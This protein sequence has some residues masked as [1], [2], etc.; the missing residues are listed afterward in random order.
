LS[1]KISTQLR[2]LVGETKPDQIKIFVNEFKNEVAKLENFSS[3]VYIGELCLDSLDETNDNYFEIFCR[4]C[5]TD[6]DKEEIVFLFK[7]ITRSK[8]SEKYNAEIRYKTIFFSKI[9]HE[10]KNPLICMNELVEQVSSSAELSDTSRFEKILKDLKQ[11]K[12]M[13]NFLII[14][15]RDF[16]FFSQN[17]VKKEII[18]EKNQTDI[19]ELCDFIQ[20]ISNSLISKFNR[21]REVKFKVEISHRVPK[22]ILTDQWRLKQILINLIS[23]AIKFTLYGEVKL[24]ITSHKTDQKKFVRFQVEDTGVG[25]KEEI[26][27]KLFQPY[28]KIANF[29]NELGS[30]LGLFIV[31]DLVNK[32]G[33]VIEF[34]SNSD[35]TAFWFSLGVDNDLDDISNFSKNDSSGIFDKKTVVDAFNINFPKKIISSRNDSSHSLKSNLDFP[36]QTLSDIQFRKVSDKK[37]LISNPVSKRDEVILIAE[38]LFNE[39]TIDHLRKSK[40]E[41]FLN[42][43]VTDDEEMILKSTVRILQEVCKKLNILINI[44]QTEDGVETI[45]SVYKCL[46]KGI[47]IDIIISDET[48]NYLIGSRAAM[49]I[50]EITSKKNI[51]SIPFYIVSAYENVSQESIYI[52]QFLTKP[53]SKEKIET[54]LSN[55]ILKNN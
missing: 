32:L 12:S 49:I 51:K 36:D 19:I 13:S 14:L 11:I 27:K 53:F 40:E 43:I 6:F 8:L 45:F 52:K 17:I 41:K 22:H 24:K 3:L 55:Y 38:N 25:I 30:G 47:T 2:N 39:K 21:C 7:D 54:I 10:F 48:M 20:D 42:I 31:K 28:S 15:V 16:D 34:K 29:S 37:S 18:I 50:H 35:G 4:I 33:G 9:A 46:S 5:K 44:I 1:D 23:N 26:Q